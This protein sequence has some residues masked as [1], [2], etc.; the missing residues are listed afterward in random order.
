MKG[1]KRLSLNF[2][3]CHTGYSDQEWVLNWGCKKLVLKHYD[4]W[5][6]YEI[7]FNAW[8]EMTLLLKEHSS[9]LIK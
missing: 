3:S 6:V 1:F 5:G 7:L 8:W 4:L 2:K 9:E